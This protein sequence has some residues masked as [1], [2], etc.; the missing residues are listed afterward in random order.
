MLNQAAKELRSV[1]YHINR[2]V[3]MGMNNFVNLQVTTKDEIAAQRDY[4]VDM[5]RKGKPKKVS[6]QLSTL[7]QVIDGHPV[8]AY[9][10]GGGRKGIA[11][12]SLK[13]APRDI[14]VHISENHQVVTEKNATWKFHGTTVFSL[15][16]RDQNIKNPKKATTVD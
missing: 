3:Q 15:Q 11:K 16:P 4:L 9:L 2:C 6:K 14:T 12:F 13:E 1:N 5:A 7:I 10:D 8:Q